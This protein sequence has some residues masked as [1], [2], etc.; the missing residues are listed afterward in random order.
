[1]MWAGRCN[2]APPRQVHRYVH[3]SP[4][5]SMTNI[6]NKVPADRA[7]ASNTTG[8]HQP[9]K[10]SNPLYRAHKKS[11]ESRLKSFANRSEAGP[12]ELRN[13]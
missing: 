8:I 6:S 4:W 7:Y 9:E 11:G 5:P 13:T 10:W 12:L 1:M 3:H 2:S